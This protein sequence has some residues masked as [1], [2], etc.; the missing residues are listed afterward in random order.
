MVWTKQDAA[1]W[2]R[3]RAEAVAVAVDKGYYDRT[4]KEQLDYYYRQKTP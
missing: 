4:K 1:E 3:E 2:K